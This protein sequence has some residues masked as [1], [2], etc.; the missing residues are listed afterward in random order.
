MILFFRAKR[1]FHLQL[2]IGIELNDEFKSRRFM[3]PS[4]ASHTPQHYFVVFLLPILW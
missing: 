4:D 2:Y 1:S 3:I